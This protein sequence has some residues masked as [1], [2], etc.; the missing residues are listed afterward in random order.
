MRNPLSRF[1]FSSFNFAG[2]FI[3]VIHCLL[4]HSHNL[5]STAQHL[6]L[7][8]ASLL[9]RSIDLHSAA[10]LIIRQCKLDCK[11]QGYCQLKL[12]RDLITYLKL[13][14]IAN[15]NLNIKFENL[16]QSNKF[17]P[18]SVSYLNPIR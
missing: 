3:L 9:L 16:F 14:L 4:L 1:F 13:N 8:G 7:S 17:E 11:F 18:D 12:N 2:K 5:C 15:C 10:P 6:M